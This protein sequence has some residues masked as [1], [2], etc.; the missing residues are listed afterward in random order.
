M[1]IPKLFTVI[2][3]NNVTSSSII[4]N[5]R[6]P[7]DFDYFY[8]DFNSIVHVISQN[9]VSRLN[10]LDRKQREK[11][12]SEETLDDEIIDRVIDFIKN[13][14]KTYSKKTLD[15]LYIAIDGVPSK[16]KLVEQGKRR[17]LGAIIH[18]YKKILLDKYE[19][20]LKRSSVR[21]EN[22]W[23]YEKTKIEF[24]KTK[25]SPSTPFLQKLSDKLRNTKF[26]CKE[27]ILSSFDEIGEGEKKII[28]HIKKMGYNRCLLY[29]PDADVILL[30]C[31]ILTGG[32]YVLRH[33][34]QTSVGE[35]QVHDL[36]NIDVL[37]NN[38]Y[39]YVDNN[40]K[41]DKNKFIYDMI[42]LMTIFGNDFVPKIE[43][44]DVQY[45]FQ[46]MLNIYF[47]TF[48]FYNDKI[49][50]I[51]Y[52][53][54][55]YYMNSNFLYKYL[56][57]YWDLEVFN[58][59]ENYMLNNF[60]M[61]KMFK[62][63]FSK[64][65][66]NLKNDSNYIN[67]TNFNDFHA[68]FQTNVKNLLHGENMEKNKFGYKYDDFIGHLKEL[69][70]YR[71][72]SYHVKETDYH[73]IKKYILNM[74]DKEFVKLFKKVRKVRKYKDVMYDNSSKS[75]RHKNALNDL[76]SEGYTTGY[77]VEY[78]KFS[79]MLDNY[80]NI[81][82]KV[83]VNLMSMDLN[84]LGKYYEIFFD[85]DDYIFVRTRDEINENVQSEKLMNVVK[86]YLEGV[87][88]TFNYY[89]N[90]TNNVSYWSYGYEKA[91]ILRDIYIYIT[92]DRLSLRKIY[93]DLK[94]YDVDDLDK[95][96]TPEEQLLYVTPKTDENKKLLN[97]K[98]IKFVE[99]SDHYLDVHK[100]ALNIDNEID[101]TGA[102]FLNKCVIKS[103][104]H[105]TMEY[106]K[107]FIVT[108]RAI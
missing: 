84:M 54:D 87:M 59:K 85:I 53:N 38:M 89:Y 23:E 71:S 95:Y 47:D 56:E 25:I 58:M 28:D 37:K 26:N 14:I 82:K 4:E 51:D 27:Y 43:S 78:Y 22:R 21:G 24:N 74:N 6:E 92:N 62:T 7:I 19:G 88:W 79:N 52:R 16:G 5:V 33:N 8:I 98:Y 11:Y 93:N 105:K 63:I 103:L 96:F 55:K 35:D 39:N 76:R 1:G 80:S 73:A 46:Q 67:H 18:E 81:M 94:K 36:I 72:F 65:S 61:Y 29:S 34:Q 49:Q 15:L 48:R 101:C 40:N 57:L 107:K 104:E 83:P 2:N 42:C 41:I 102:R 10:K 106:D 68:L 32:N 60:R 20:E 100:M 66:Y 90:E 70:N 99:T 13:L 69:V 64:G 31:L 108:V 75:G 50:L 9:M 45:N 91:P 17:Y 97:Q 86:K 77:D 44:I 12:R 3:K 30:A